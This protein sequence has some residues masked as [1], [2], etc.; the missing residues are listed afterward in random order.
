MLQVIVAA[1]LDRG[2]ERGSGR[3]G[4]G[5][6]CNS[7]AGQRRRRVVRQQVWGCGSRVGEKLGEGRVLV[8]G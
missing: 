2:E 1:D 7:R 5:W 4:L 3:V 6:C 8:E